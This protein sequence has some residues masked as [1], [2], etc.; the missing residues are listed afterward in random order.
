M[1]LYHVVAIPEPGV[2]ALV[3]AGAGCLLLRFRR[4]A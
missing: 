3:I 1:A 2:L 4:I